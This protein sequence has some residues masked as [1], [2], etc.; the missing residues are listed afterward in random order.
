[1]T[2]LSLS[3][4][5][6][7]RSPD[8]PTLQ[9]DLRLH[10]VPPTE[11]EASVRQQNVPKDTSLQVVLKID[12]TE[13][14]CV[15]LKRE[16]TLTV[17]ADE[18]LITR[19]WCRPSTREGEIALGPIVLP[20]A[21]LEDFIGCI[22]FAL[23]LETDQ[24]VEVT[25]WTEQCFLTSQDS[26]DNRR[27]ERMMAA[28]RDHVD[29]LTDTGTVTSLTTHKER[30]HAGAASRRRLRLSDYRNLIGRILQVYAQQHRFFEKSARF[31]LQHHER[32]TAIARVEAVTYRTLEFIASHPEEL[33]PF[34]RSTGIRFRGKSY[35]PRRTVDE[36][37]QK[38]FD[39]LENRC[40]VAFLQT[41]LSSVE[42]LG[43]SFSSADSRASSALFQTTV[44]SVFKSRG[45][46]Q[47]QLR[48]HTAAY[49]KL[50]AI[51]P[52]PALKTL[53]APTPIFMSSV[54]Y[55]Q[56][57]E[58]MRQ[59]FSAQAPTASEVRFLLKVSQSSRLYEHYV[60][61]QLLT[62]FGASAM[63]K[64]RLSYADAPKQ[65][66]GTVACNVYTFFCVETEITLYYEPVIPAGISRIPNEV[67]LVRTM[68]FDFSPT[69]LPLGH[70]QETCW[71]PDFVIRLRNAAGTRYWL[72]DAKYSS[73]PT[74]VKNYAQ[75]VLMK[76]L[77]ATAPR[78]PEDR[79]CGLMLFC[80]KDQGADPALKSFR[81]VDC[82]PQRG[83]PLQFMTLSA[84]DETS[85]RERLRE[86]IMSTVLH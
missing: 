45:E 5:L 57:Y 2:D 58:L 33:V 78:H 62:A 7:I 29:V 75:E 51:D 4:V 23:S 10:S 40:L 43:Q 24:G 21:G 56:I 18:Q 68:T 80:G 11:E 17:R 12:G 46:L 35:F 48:R 85:E 82:V 67:G 37:H 31:Q 55:R 3:G 65:Y 14:A 83:Q 64:R 9:C 32:M 22:G 26:E 60:L 28:L 34:K 47:T 15:L 73:W 30:T 69:G 25:L 6:Q 63:E 16:V 66:R 8:D 1:M 42:T 41:V 39:I 59:W 20:K 86:W 54:P 81:N 76:Y 72:A 84:A 77:L 70:P 50:F 19:Q 53:P 13:T 71:T 74:V 52:P 61:L 36:I 44:A 38:T 49:L 27:L 79:I